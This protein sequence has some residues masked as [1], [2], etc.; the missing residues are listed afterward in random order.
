MSE[1][2]PDIYGYGICTSGIQTED[3]KK[4]EAVLALA[5]AYNECLQEYFKEREI[6]EPSWDDYMDTDVDHG[7]G[8]PSILGEV[9]EEAEGIG[10][11]PCDD[12][13]G[14]TFLLYEPK[15]PWH[16]PY[17]EKDLTEDKLR[18]IF[19]K[20]V[21][22]LTDEEIEVEYHSIEIVE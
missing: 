9:I 2:W 21:R 20:Y 16:L 3:V 7:L 19:E 11:T 15:Y 12:C 8:L 6:A 22:I 17:A 5:P 1:T 10:L 4:L 18:E 14:A 13:D